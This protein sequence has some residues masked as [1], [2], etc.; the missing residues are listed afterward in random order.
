MNAKSAQLFVAG[1]REKSRWPL[2]PRVEKACKVIEAKPELAAML[3]RQQALD[4]NAL[5]VLERITAPENLQ[6]TLAALPS[7]PPQKGD[8]KRQLFQPAILGVIFGLLLICGFGI[9]F[10]L[11]RTDSF[12]G[13]DAAQEMIA[14]TQSMT[15]NEMESVSKPAGEMGDWLFL[16]YGLENF[17]IPPD[18]A[19]FKTVGCRL[20]KQ[21]GHPIAQIAAEPHHV[22]FYVFRSSDF[23]VVLKT[24]D[25]WHIFEQD[26]WVAALRDDGEMCFMVAFRG[27]EDAMNA[28]L[29]KESKSSGE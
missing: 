8:W 15:G 4:V 20:L 3:A 6:T 13:L 2:D 17:A 14:V 22:L 12:P 5:N 23:G 9:Y 16:K 28:F 10:W 25:H 21:D 27:D 11:T 29:S 24:P 18:F 19:A 26:D 1:L 7:L